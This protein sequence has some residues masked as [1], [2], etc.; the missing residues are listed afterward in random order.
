MDSD[1]LKKIPFFSSL[2]I[3]QRDLILSVCRDI[4]IPS[5]KVII[6]Q[7]DITSDLYI[8][9]S[10]SVKVSLFG[11]DGSEIVLEIIKE[12]DFFGELS[13]FD[14]RPR[15]ATVT[16]TTDCKVLVL[17]RDAFINMIRKDHEMV[18]NFLHIMAE[19]LR[20]ADER[21]ETLAFF[22]VYGRVAKLLIEISNREGKRLPD[23]SISI[24]RPT[25]HEIAHQVAASREAVTKAMQS[26]ILHDLIKVNKGSI[27]ITPKQFKIL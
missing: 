20:K 12:G 18:M 24:K 6:N 23:G 16:A 27:V 15:S 9:L 3:K 26:L 11:K 8:L 1:Y 2:D 14:K 7:E 17:S 13:L 19:R 5:G 21:I 10:G 22:D 25:H 4:R